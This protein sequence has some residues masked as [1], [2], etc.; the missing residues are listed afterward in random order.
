MAYF[1]KEQCLHLLLALLGI[2]T[3]TFSSFLVLEIILSGT[4]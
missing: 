3:F 2:V 4:K 1:L